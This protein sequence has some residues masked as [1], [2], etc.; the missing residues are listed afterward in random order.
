MQETIARIK[1]DVSAKGIMHFAEI[2]QSRLAAGAGIQ[3]RPSTLLI[4][5]N[6]P[7]GTLFISAKPEA[8]L[9][10]PV[11][12]LVSQDENGQVWA[13]YT[14]FKWI[15]Q[16]HGITERDGEFATATGVIASITSAI[17]Q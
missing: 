7:L 8:G 13:M 16:R 10:W 1:A 15:A 2:D 4:F 14:D 17:R 5:G 9:D 6:P 3:L 11:R 12:L